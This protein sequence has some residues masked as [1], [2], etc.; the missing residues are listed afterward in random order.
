MKGFFILI[1][2]L[3]TWLRLSAATQQRPDTNKLSAPLNRVDSLNHPV[4]LNHADSIK[5]I[6]IVRKRDSLRTALLV[7]KVV[8]QAKLMRPDSLK[9]LVKQTLTDTLKGPLYTELASR[10][11][12]YD[13]ISDIK[14]RL[15]YQ[16]YALNYTLQALHQ[17]S[18]CNDT[19]GL[20]TSFDNLAKV[21]LSQKRYSEAKWFIL[22]SNSLSRA[23]NDVVNIIASLITLA[24]IK[25]KVKD[26]KLAENDLD[27][28]L[29]LSIS[30]H[31]QK[32]ELQVLKNYALMYSRMN[33]YPK[34]ALM[35]KKRDSLEKRIS[36][37]EEASVARASA[38]SALKKRK[39]DSSQSKKKTYS[40]NTKKLYK[41][42]SS[43]KTASS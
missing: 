30:N 14:S 23:K 37:E 13:T 4:I 17:Y 21:Y 6:I 12:S 9:K 40:S 18:R 33:N 39:Q 42:K 2:V 3:F 20:R 25:S 29:R 26:Y 1:I 43:K 34:E 38:E 22:Q 35:L 16:N 24:D 11:L 7:S 15:A 5:L 41:G 27:E 31:Y 19:A 10:Y 28:A 36:R 32:I 8:Q